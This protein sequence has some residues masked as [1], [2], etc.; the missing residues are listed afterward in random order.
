MINPAKEKELVKRFLPRSIISSFRKIIYPEKIKL[1]EENLNALLCEHYRELA[2]PDLQQ[3]IALKNSEFKVYSKNGGDGILLHIFSKIGVTNRTFVEMG[4]EDGQECN[5]ANLSLNFGWN[6]MLIDANN[7]WIESAKKFYS[8]KL[9][10]KD[11][12]VRPVT[13]FI[14]AENINETISQNGISGEIDLLSIDIDGNDYWVWKALDVVSPR[15]VMA[16][17]NAAFGLRPIT[18]KYNKEHRYEKDLYFGASLSALTKLANAK[19][20]VLIGCDSQ[21][22]DAFF[23]RRDDAQGKFAEV[24]PHDAFYSNPH[25][26][27]EF[28]DL[29]SQFHQVNDLDFDEV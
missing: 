7:A 5:T 22:H 16:E 25:F 13:S 26:E 21:G 10:A 8:S 3:K 27:A 17:Y 12:K 15:V 11:D 28:G 9:G 29:E 18:I 1:V 23:V 2:A 4:V 24:T 14:T 20:Y 6:G 19:G